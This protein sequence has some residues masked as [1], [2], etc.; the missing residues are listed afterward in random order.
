M[1]IG[2]ENVHLVRAVMDEVFG[3]E[4]FVS[5]VFVAKTSGFGDTLT[6][7]SVGEY[8]L[9]YAKNRGVVKYR[10]LYSL[11]TQDSPFAREYR[12]IENSDRSIRRTLSHSEREDSSLMPD[13]WK[14]FRPS[15]TTSQGATTTGV[16]IPILVPI[17]S[18]L[19]G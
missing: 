14:R 8:L 13:G 16:K 4:N 17:K 7:S 5:L 1:Q 6:L 3:S 11:K 2:D 10:Q 9:W 12:F 18:R 19:I 15:A